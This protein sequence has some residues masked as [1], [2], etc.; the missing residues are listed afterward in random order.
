MIEDNEF[1]HFLMYLLHVRLFN[2]VL[3]HTIQ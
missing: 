3:F 1:I 2:I